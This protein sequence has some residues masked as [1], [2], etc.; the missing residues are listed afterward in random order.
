L[1]KLQIDDDS[2][3]KDDADSYSENSEESVDLTEEEEKNDKLL[4]K[5]G[6]YTQLEI[7]RLKKN[8]KK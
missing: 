2:E 8:K 6:F 4:S 5:R 7:K 1:N 3:S